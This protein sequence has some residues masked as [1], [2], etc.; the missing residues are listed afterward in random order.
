MLPPD[1][2]FSERRAS[3]CKASNGKYSRKKTGI[4]RKDCYEEVFCT[5]TMSSLKKK[6]TEEN[7]CSIWI[8]R[9]YDEWKENERQKTTL[10]EHLTKKFT[11]Q[12]PEEIRLIND[13]L[14]P[15]DRLVQNCSGIY[16]E[17]EVKVEKNILWKLSCFG[18]LKTKAQS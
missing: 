18:L 10:T 3:C 8:S 11:I 16:N 15:S 7:I 1:G 13:C 6:L 9:N 4:K 5:C 2:T 17:L 12:R 14:G